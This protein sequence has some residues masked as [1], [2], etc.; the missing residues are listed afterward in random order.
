MGRWR[1][2]SMRR[3]RRRMMGKTER[4]EGGGWGEDV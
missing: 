4:G 2:K 3:W 1:R